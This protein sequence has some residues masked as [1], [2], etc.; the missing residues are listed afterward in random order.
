MLVPS[1]KNLSSYFQAVGTHDCSHLPPVPTM[2]PVWK[3]TVRQPTF[4]RW[5]VLLLPL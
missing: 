1:F 4:K 3:H 2:I 5:L